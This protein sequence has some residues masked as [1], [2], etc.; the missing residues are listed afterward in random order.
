MIR[1]NWEETQ[2]TMIGFVLMENAYDEEQD[3]GA[4]I[5]FCRLYK[6]SGYCP[7]LGCEKYERKVKLPEPPKEKSDG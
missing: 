6:R 4:H 7:Y 2:K 5:P 3:M 1:L